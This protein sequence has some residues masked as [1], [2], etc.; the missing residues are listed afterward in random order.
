MLTLEFLKSILHY[1]PETGIWT[2]LVDRGRNGKKGSVAG[3]L[4]H[5][6]YWRI[7]VNKK[8]YLSHRLAFFYITG[9][10]P[11]ELVDHKDTDKLNNKWE[12]LREATSS[13]NNRNKKVTSRNSTG[14]KGVGK[15]KDGKFRVY[16]CLGTF[17]TKE[18]AK[19]VYDEA[20]K[21]L[22]GEFYVS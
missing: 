11:K 1:D 9:E 12:N 5:D 20:A 14:L 4:T 21:K 18:E 15:A 7:L 2:Y 13:E 19:R 22:H 3:S 16:L 8:Q 10:W 17:D 6:G